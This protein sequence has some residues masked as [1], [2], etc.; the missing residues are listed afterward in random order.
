VALSGTRVVAVGRY[1]RLSPPEGTSEAEVALVIED[2]HQGRGI[3]SLLLRHLAFAARANGIERF[4]GL[5]LPETP[6]SCDGS[7]AI[8]WSG[9]GPTGSCAWRFPWVAPSPHSEHLR[10][11]LRAPRAL[12]F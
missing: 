5:V 1:E 3:G 11:P 4:A 9:A 12:C 10:P 8:R 6:A 2:A 7:P